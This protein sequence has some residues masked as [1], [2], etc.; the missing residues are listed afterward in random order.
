MFEL[1]QEICFSENIP[2]D[3]MHLT[4]LSEIAQYG[5]VAT[6]ALV[7]NGKIVISGKVPNK[8]K[9]KEIILKELDLP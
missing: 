8:E 2:A 7:I 5:L 6:P 9:I 4:D 1:V 3:L